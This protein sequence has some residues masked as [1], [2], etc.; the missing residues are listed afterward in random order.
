VKV[1]VAEVQLALRVSVELFP[2][3]TLVG[4]KLAVTPA[5]DPPTLAVKIGRAACRESADVAVVV[6]ALLPPWVI[7][8]E[9]GLGAGLKAKSLVAAL[10]VSD[11]EVVCVADSSGPLIVTVKVPV[12]E[13]QLALRVSVELFPAVTLVGLKLAV[14]PAG[15]PPTLAVSDTDCALPLVTAVEM[16]LVDRKSVV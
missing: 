9:P 14:T 15:D 6:V 8:T 12:A 13:V 11:S 2:A 7:V 10:P 4:L 5:G 16:V 3:V 1:P